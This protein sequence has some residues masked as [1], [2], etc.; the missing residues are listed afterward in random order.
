MKNLEVEYLKLQ[1]ENELMLLEKQQ[2]SLEM[3]LLKENLEELKLV[4]TSIEV[5]EVDMCEAQ[6]ILELAQSE[7]SYSM[8]KLIR[9]LQVL[10]TKDFRYKIDSDRAHINSKT[11]ISESQQFHS[12]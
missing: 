2:M 12:C 5:N 9:F 11:L 10:E 4:K 1:D 3:K 7:L 8:S 6:R